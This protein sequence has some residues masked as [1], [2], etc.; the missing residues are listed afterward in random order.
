MS[1]HTDPNVSIHSN[2]MT[3]PPR[4]H[5]EIRHLPGDLAVQIYRSW[6]TSP[7][8]LRDN[9]TDLQLLE[10]E[11]HLLCHLCKRPCAGTCSENNTNP[12]S[13]EPR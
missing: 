8:A 13:F 6:W 1:D 4:R 12:M 11:Q 2:V 10:I 7:R 9:L 3:V 5:D